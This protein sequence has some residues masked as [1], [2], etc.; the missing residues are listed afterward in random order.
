MLLSYNSGIVVYLSLDEWL[1]LLQYAL[2]YARFWFISGGGGGG[3]ATLSAFRELTV[4]N[5]H[6]TL[7]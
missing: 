7:K 4:K 2:P 1:W 6:Q 5:T 3:T